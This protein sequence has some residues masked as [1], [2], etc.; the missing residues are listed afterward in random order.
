MKEVNF[1][2][3]QFNPAELIGSEWLTIT[4]GNK[5]TGCN[6]MT[7]SWAHLGAIW[8]RKGGPGNIP[9]AVVYVRHSRYTHEFME[10]EALFSISVLKPEFKKAH[11]ILGN[12]SGRDMDKYAA[13][14]LHPVYD[15]GTA[16]IAESKLA[17]IC[18]KLYTDEIKPECFIDQTL[19]GHNYADGDF[20]TL[21]IGEIIKTL[22]E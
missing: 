14:G 18:R 19:V 4:A 9:T 5:D 12:E 13:T 20:H 21:Y 22:A 17:L 6:S 3:L 2:D 11:A 16:F 10:K 1:L 15:Y 8:G 7:A